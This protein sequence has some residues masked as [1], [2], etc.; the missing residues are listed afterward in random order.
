[1]LSSRSSAFGL[2]RSAALCFAISMV[3]FPSASQADPVVNFFQSIGRTMS[4]SNQKPVVKP[5]ARNGKPHPQD[6]APNSAAPAMT[7]G[8]PA[9]SPMASASPSPVA[10]NS[11]TA[12]PANV[13]RAT[14]ANSETHGSARD[15]PYA[16]P[17]PN[18]VGFVTSPYAPN[19]GLVD[20][21][22]FRSGTEVKDP[23]TGKFFLIP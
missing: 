20:V 9:A 10:V 15:V 12:P 5:R 8:S 16:I 11:P 4:R 17:V 23:F 7:T 18:K 21:R 22:G 19:Q 2:A 3:S 13:V 14:I 1:M 6:R